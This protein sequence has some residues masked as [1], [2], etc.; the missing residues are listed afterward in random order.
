LDVF[1]FRTS[2][3]LQAQ[4][5]PVKEEGG[6]GASLGIILFFQAIMTIFWAFRN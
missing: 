1:P 6:A 5:Y 2:I 4:F 3:C